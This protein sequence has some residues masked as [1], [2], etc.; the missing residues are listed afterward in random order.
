MSSS[1]GKPDLPMYRPEGAMQ[2]PYR[3][4]QR[5]WDA[6]MGT[7]L[8]HAENWRRIA[9]LSIIALLLTLA[10]FI[11]YANKATVIPYI[12]ERG[13]KGEVRLVGKLEHKS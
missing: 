8:V 4:G 1:F 11:Y 3:D 2:T 6:R 13:P 5:E 7:T 9:F 12:V 10:G